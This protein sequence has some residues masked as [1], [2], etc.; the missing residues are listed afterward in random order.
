MNKFICLFSLVFSL[1]AQITQIPGPGGSGGTISGLTTGTYPVAASATTLA[2][3]LIT[4]SAGALSLNP[5]SGGATILGSSGA[6]ILLETSAASV[7]ANIWITKHASSDSGRLIAR[8]AATVLWS[9]GTVGNDSFA[10][11]DNVNSINIL[12]IN[13]VTTEPIAVGSL[14]TCNSG[15]EGTHKAVNNSNA[16]SYTLGIGAV[17]AA[18]GTTHV[19]VYCDGTN[20]RIG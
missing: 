13:S 20:W 5:T 6:N 1:S 9:I 7:D 8:D 3:G 15:A 2:N 4:Q 19:P 18:G 14:G 11:T 12:T 16:T 17:V 10:I